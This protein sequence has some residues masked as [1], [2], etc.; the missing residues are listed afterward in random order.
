MMKTLTAPIPN[1]SCAHCVHT[2]ET[3]LGELPGVKNVEVRADIKNVTIVYDSPA[4][5]ESIEAFL[6]EINYP[7]V[8]HA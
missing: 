5:E 4:T 3:E 2:I 6:A 8:R 7:I 1:I